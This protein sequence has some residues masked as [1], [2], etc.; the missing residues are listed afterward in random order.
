MESSFSCF[1]FEIKIFSPL[2]KAYKERCHIKFREIQNI[3]LRNG[4]QMSPQ[5]FDLLFHCKG[6]HGLDTLEAPLWSVA[7]GLAQNGGYSLLILMNSS[8]VAYQNFCWYRNDLEFFDKKYKW[9][10]ENPVDFFHPRSPLKFACKNVFSLI[11][12]LIVKGFSYIIKIKSLIIF[13]ETIL[14]FKGR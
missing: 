6:H 11:N 9:L 14:A 13:T 2:S 8:K 12:I 4:H 3:S 1:L 5:F 10:L 7:F